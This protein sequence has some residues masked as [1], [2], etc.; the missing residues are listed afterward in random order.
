M[1]AI[2]SSDT[3]GVSLSSLAT[4]GT[5]V[6]GPDTSRSTNGERAFVNVA[7]GNLALRVQD[8]YLASTGADIAAVRTYNSQ[9]QLS[10]QATWA[11]G[12]VRQSVVLVTAAGTLGQAGSRLARTDAD[13]AT[14]VYNWDTGRG[15]YVTSDGAG[16]DDT[17]ELVAGGGFKWTDGNTRLVETYSAAG[18]LSSAV[19]TDGQQIQYVYKNRA[20]STDTS[21]TPDGSTLQAYDANG[22][23]TSVTDGKQ[24]ASPNNRAFVNDA[25]GRLLY[26]NQGG[27][28]QRQLIANGQVLGR[29][30]EVV[31]DKVA[32]SQGV[33][34]FTSVAQFGFGFEAQ[35]GDTPRSQDRSH[36][37]RAGDTLQGLAQ[38]YF[39]D[40]RLWYRI[41]EANGMASNTELS[42]GQ[43]V[44]IP[45]GTERAANAA[46]TFKPYDPSEVV[47]DTSPFI[48]QPKKKSSFLKKLIV[49]IV[50]VVVAYFTQQWQ[51]L[52]DMSVLL[53]GAIMGAAAS[54]AGQ[55]TGM[56][57]G[58]Q[59]KFSWKQVALSAIGGG[60]SAGLPT[61][62]LLGT[63]AGSIPNTMLRAAI[64]NTLTQGIGV[65]TGLQKSFDWRGVAASAVGAGVGQMVG[66][67]LGLDNPNVVRGMSPG[68]LFG[69]RL[70]T[71][72]AAGAAAAVARGGKVEIQQVAVDAF[73]N[74]LGESLAS[75]MSSPSISGTEA[76]AADLADRKRS[77]DPHGLRAYASDAAGVVRSAQ[78][79]WGAS[80]AETTSRT[81]SDTSTDAE[82]LASEMHGDHLDGDLVSTGGGNVRISSGA[83]GRTMVN[84]VSVNE[85]AD[86]SLQAAGDL[87]GMGEVY[88]D[89]RLLGGLMSEL[90]QETTLNKLK[91]AV[92][93]KL[94]MMRVLP[95]P[96][97]LG[98]SPG[99]GA[100]GSVRYNNV[101]LIDRYSDAL[102]KVE[103][104][105]QGI[106][107][108]DTRSMLIT[109]IGTAKLSPADWVAE[110]TRRYANAFA[111][112]IDEGQ[113][114]YDAGTLRYP[115]DMPGQLQV[116]SFADNAARVAVIAYNRSIGVPEGPGQLLS[117][118]R[119]SYDP[120]GSGAYNR[121]DLLMDLGPSR[122]NG[123][124]ILRTAIEGKSTLAAVQSSSAQLQ[125]VYEWN[126]PNI[127]TVTRQGALPWAPAQ[128]KRLR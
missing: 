118:N 74:A 98:A 102:R 104:W 75:E 33:P 128:P 99:I 76:W 109:S 90:Q 97:A 106:I 54:T 3:L 89:Y 23:L 70:A 82:I 19:D 24:S 39:G 62:D 46:D 12:T 81:L 85:R 65:V 35:G 83:G 105:K 37:L 95:S 22:F 112:G 15:F 14:A 116:G 57:L 25:A 86:R 122:N 88:R 126:T 87:A 27:H 114:R 30:G 111:T 113:R 20:S 5:G 68:Q 40:S 115:E 44:K 4:L 2:V 56:A 120:S 60:V 7:T 84:G 28:V 78:A 49:A 31:D 69:A 16:A 38:M 17:L 80:P 42:P 13:G 41:A 36:V 32:R 34:S 77:L 79:L 72:L 119:W 8:E 107:E 124:L 10:G 123:A 55:V 50:A 117:M 29:Y 26:A 73:G 63:K 43:L 71:G 121:I 21:G 125:R 66:G 61:G 110:N 100:D 11:V 47:G 9:G 108:L 101:D 96:E 51:L 18:R 93:E 91:G 45:G 48:P 6:P 59:D 94:G 127:I 52:K 92:Q 64:G 67:A 1:V 103:M 53:K 58:I